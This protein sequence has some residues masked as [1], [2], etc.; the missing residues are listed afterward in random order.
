LSD[1]HANLEAL[2]ACLGHARSRGADRFALLGDFVGYG[3]DAAASS[4]SSSA[5]RATGAIVLKGNHD[6]AIEKPTSWFNDA[7]RASLA[8]ARETLSRSRSAFSPRC[9]SCT[10]DGEHCYRARVRGVAGALG[11]R[12]QPDAAR[13]C[14]TRRRRATRFA[15]TSTTRRCSSKRPTDG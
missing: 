1:I 4:P 13:R 2:E 7:A 11:L 10:R 5:M 8:W 9:R 14:A 6:Q 12:R 3:A 15:G